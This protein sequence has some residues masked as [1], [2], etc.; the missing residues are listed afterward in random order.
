MFVLECL[1]KHVPVFFDLVRQRNSGL[2]K[3]LTVIDH[4]YHSEVFWD[5][6]ENLPEGVQEFQSID[7][8]DI[9]VNFKYTQNVYSMRLSLT[10]SHKFLEYYAKV[11][12][13]NLNVK[14]Y[15]GVKA[16]NLS[17]F[18]WQEQQEL[19]RTKLFLDITG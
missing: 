6:P 12:Q 14:H 9:I 19:Y 17:P 3:Q 2:L 11:L 5:V 15:Q 10:D 8:H 1:H 16:K 7:M 18:N 4:D 13:Q